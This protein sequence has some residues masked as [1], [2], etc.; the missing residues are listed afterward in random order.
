LKSLLVPLIAPEMQEVDKNTNDFLVRYKRFYPR[1]ATEAIF[2]YLTFILRERDG[3]GQQGNCARPSKSP[4]KLAINYKQ[5]EIL[6][7]HENLTSKEVPRGSSDRSVGIVFGAVFLIAAVL[8]LFTSGGIRVWAVITSAA[9][10]LIAFVIPAL[11]APLNKIWTRFGLLLHRIV[12]PVV[13]G[14]LF[15][16]FVTPMGL[17]MR[18]MGKD[19]LRLRFDSSSRS[20]WIER[21]PPGPRPD[22]LNNQF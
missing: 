17:I 6:M 19:F 3:P 21:N 2:L 20:Y 9:F 18:L 13:L 4:K 16:L 22:S 8:P 14:I 10:F 11:L 7:A 1:H 15:Y 12:S 5:L